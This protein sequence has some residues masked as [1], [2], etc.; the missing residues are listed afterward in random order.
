MLNN[1]PDACS[2][3]DC[4]CREGDIRPSAGRKLVGV[5][6]TRSTLSAIKRLS[7]TNR[8]ASALAEARFG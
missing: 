2:P 8:S 5:T 6:L 1:S 4:N 3:R 7:A